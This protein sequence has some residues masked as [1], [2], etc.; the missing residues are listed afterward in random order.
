MHAFDLAMLLIRL[1][2]GVTF[3]AHGAQKAF[4]WWGGPGLKG[5][6]GAIASMGFRPV[7]LFAGLSVLGELVGG[8]MLAAG[9]LSPAA[10]A[11]LVAQSVVIILKVHWSHGFFNT[12][13]GSE[14]PLLLAV[15]AVA[16][17]VAGPGQ[18]SVDNL[19]KLEPSATVRGAL[20]VLG[21]VGG[22]VALAIPWLAAPKAV[23]QQV[24]Q[25]A[26]QAPAKSAPAAASKPAR[27]SR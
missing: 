20:L 8:L 11:V 2:V 24:A 17:G 14:Y 13:G 3:A 27:K 15:A 23:P 4:G 9:I 19:L 16:V 12:K 10:A 21:G 1:G 25:A 6:W 7:A 18:I 26:P 22:L 5:W